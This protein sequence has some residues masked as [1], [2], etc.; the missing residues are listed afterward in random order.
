VIEVWV[1]VAV[2]PA[3]ACRIRLQTGSRDEKKFF[4]GVND[5]VNL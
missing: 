2:P 3:A 5:V 4:A 1:A